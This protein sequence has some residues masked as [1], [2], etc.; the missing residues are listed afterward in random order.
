M[1]PST[2]MDD[3]PVVVKFILQSIGDSDAFEVRVNI[4]LNPS[5]YCNKS[6][7]STSKISKCSLLITAKTII[8]T[9]SMVKK[10]HLNDHCDLIGQNCSL[11]GLKKFW[12]VIKTGDLL[13][14]IFSP[15]HTAQFHSN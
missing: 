5:G 2:E 12:P 4:V 6:T 7:E 11:S 3:L 9:C 13:F 14:V 1:L 10:F 8:S 15:D